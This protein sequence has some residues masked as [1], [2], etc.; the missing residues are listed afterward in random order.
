MH[1]RAHVLAPASH[2]CKACSTNPCKAFGLGLFKAGMEMQKSRT[3]HQAKKAWLSFSNTPVA[4]Q[5][6][7]TYI[8]SKGYKESISEAVHLILFFFCVIQWPSL[9]TIW[10]ASLAS[11]RLGPAKVEE[12]H[13]IFARHCP[14]HSHSLPGPS[15]SSA[16][17]EHHW[18][19]EHAWNPSN[20]VLQV[21]ANSALS[22]KCSWARHAHWNQSLQLAATSWKHLWWQC[23]PWQ[24]FFPM[25]AGF[26]NQ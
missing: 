3:L 25:I 13:A 22:K 5:M 7:L 10:K 9:Q 16:S 20:T 6:V 8:A 1:F 4:K 19:K 2:Q 24:P 23:F 21:L 12:I 11:D 14:N 18:S 26:P 15:K 17:K